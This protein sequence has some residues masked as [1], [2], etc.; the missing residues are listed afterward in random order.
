VSLVS[1]LKNLTR[2]S[3]IYTLSTFL[4]RALGF[5]MLPFYTDARYLESTAS[6]GRYVVIYTF[7]AFMNV[8]YLY[9][10]D[11]AL[12]RFLF[13][14]RH[15]R[16][17]LY[18]T[19]F[20]ALLI[21]SLL[22][23]VL[24]WLL[25]PKLAVLLFGDPEYSFFLKVSAGILFFDTMTNLPFVLL[26]A[27]EKA[28]QYTLFRVL[29]FALELVLNVFFVLYL[30]QGV[31]GI[32]YANLSAAA[33]NWI[34]LWPMQ[35]NWLKGRFTKTGLVDLLKFGLPMLPNGLAYLVIEVS[36]KYL[37]SWLLDME[38]VGMYG[39][40]YK[41]GSVLLLLVTAFRTAWMPFFLKVAGEP[42]AKR[43]YS[44]VLTMF[45][46]VAVMV[47]VTAGMFAAEI[48]RIPL[49]G[50]RTLI[51]AKYWAGVSIIP[52]IL[53]SY[54]FY[55]WYVNFMVGIYIEKKSQWMIVFTGLGAVVNVLSNLYLMPRYGMMGAAFATLLSYMVLAFST[56]LANHRFY[57]VPY[58]YPKLI[59]LLFYLAAM[60]LV[61][62]FVPLG[63]AEKLIIVPL[64]F[65]FFFL[66]R[67]V[68][69][70]DFRM[71]LRR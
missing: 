10:L 63:F 44:K 66:F 17:D 30:R 12:M 33:V 23:S 52:I 31:K 69:W 53:T 59:L 3:A 5:V 24:I 51:G 2:N 54:L 4:Q 39:A 16:K 70:Q 64:S 49:P 18:K 26:R 48:Q 61:W 62:Y 45:T 38:T 65:S 1:H 56:G 11:S 43:I 68:R 20:G 7:I 41:F 6:F 35:F 67:L 42:E 55:G 34:I 46:L 15:E 19:A 47:I 22:L 58:E 25:A 32:L 29:R 8:V 50:N 40:N 27:E 9:G 60:L 57:P 28:G 71:A 14:G 21:N 36:D 13:I 37:M